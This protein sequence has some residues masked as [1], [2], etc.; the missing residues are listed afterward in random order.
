MGRGGDSEA[1]SRRR[2]MKRSSSVMERLQQLQP[3]FDAK[4]RLRSWKND[5]Q[6]RSSM[7]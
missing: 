7:S 5:L 2:L 3:A 6:V 4:E 1:V